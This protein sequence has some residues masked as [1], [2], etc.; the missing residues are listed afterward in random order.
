M[1]LY[2]TSYQF[3]SIDPGINLGGVK[4]LRNA[5]RDTLKPFSAE[6]LHGVVDLSTWPTDDCVRR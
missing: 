2:L 4:G 6:L 1:I 5:K 3:E